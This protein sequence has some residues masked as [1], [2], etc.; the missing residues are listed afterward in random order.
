MSSSQA[1][2]SSKYSYRATSTGPGAA[3]VNIEYIQDL[4]SLSRLEDKIRLLQDDL[5]VERELRQRIEREKADLSVQV[6]QMSERL[7]EAEGGA[8]HQF[9]ANRKRDAELL[10]L[11]KLLEDVH[12]ES[13][14]TTVLLKKKHNE[15]IT[16][17]QEQ[18]E[19]LTK[20]KARAE[21]DKAKFQAEVYELLS[22]IE[23]YN[24]EK[25]VSE[26][27]ISKLEISISELN[28]KIEELNRTVIDITSHKSRLSQENIELIKDVQDLKTQLDTVSFSKSQV[29][30]QLEDARRRL[31]DEDRRRSLL[32][33]SL[34]QV[35]IE[36]DS[37]RNQLEEESEAR[38][39]LERQLVKANADAT[40]WQNK[41]N[42]EVAARAEEVEEIRR[43]Y[44]VR[45]TELEEHIET[46]IVKVN[47]LEKT[48][49]RLA[50][51]VEV[52]IIDL[53]KSNN[54]CRELTKSV[55]TLE[56]H[57]VE[58]KSRLDETIVLFE[59]SQ[60]DLKNKQADLVRTVHELDKVKDAN[61]Q[62][63]RE[64]KK[65]GDDLH[66]AKGAINELNRRLHELELELRRLEN[67]RDELTAAYKEAEA[68]RKAEEQRGQRLAADFNQYRHDAERRLAEKDEEIEA[69]RK[70][71]SIEIEQLNARVIEAETRL[72]TEV[73]R[74]K[75]KLQIQITELE[76]SLDVANKTNIDLQKVIKKQSLQLTELQ[77]HY[78][79]VQ[80]QL[81]ATLDQ[82]A[83]AQR[84]LA[85]LNGE[86]EEVR[87][88][89]D[90]ANRAKR[91]VELQYEEAST[92]IN[93]LSTANVNLV[94]I[95]SKLE[96]ELTVVA[97]DY[98]EV[99]KE[100]R[101]S[102]ERYQK[103][104]V[105][106][107]HV[108]EQVHEEQERIVKLETIKKSLEVEVK[109]LSIRLEEVELNAV[110]GSK[111]I[112]SKLEARIRDLELELEEEK[113]RHAETIKI[114]RK[115]ERTV[116]EV[117][118]QCEED[119]KNIILLQDALDKTT[120]KIN[121]YRRQLS[122]QEGATQQTTTRVRRFQRELEAAEDRADVAESNLNLIR[123]K[124][125]T[126][127]TTS[128][129]PGSQVYIQETTRTITE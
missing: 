32:E 69:I 68:G 15:I 47:N 120:A 18:V 81:Q 38:I 90:S 113:R 23:S 7:E 27:H 51:E 104:T 50:S 102:D 26:K 93:E 121:I 22:Q 107:K 101:I 111:R 43:K 29:I 72:K 11:R 46:L 42:A 10:K 105:E 35:E 12:L 44:Q 24:K 118:V 45:I 65:L 40:S 85:G 80:R 28:V 71:T 63:A 2:R 52:L 92:R 127:V 114:L 1:V 73:T 25:I 57:N 123:A 48:K 70:Q 60:R 117:I 74:I 83:V 8:E 122:E 119:Q 17:F 14:E 49:T 59:T 106:L 56:K 95:K 30:S 126:F 75:K 6:I 31:E 64:N 5:E 58:L 37:V 116:K 100:L 77:A 20:N 91:T 3:D 67:E 88:H 13:E 4:S 109:N 96:Q 55:N 87:S 39:D 34:H 89:L 33:S 84:R 82:Y 124:H 78:E 16:D 86:L 108:V 41:W 62:F 129:V 97:S 76:M 79:D 103:V 94:S 66:D 36:L 54:S 61:N 9:E 112:I 21:K 98:E 19:I 115:K 128:T 53:E 110:A 125:R 99:S